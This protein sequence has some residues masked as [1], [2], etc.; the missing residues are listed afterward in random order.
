MTRIYAFCPGAEPIP[1]TW[2]ACLPR[3]RQERLKKISHFEAWQECLSLGLLYAYALEAWGLDRNEPVHILP[4]G[5][6][7]FSARPAV[8]FSLSH[9]GGWVVCA[10]SNQSV[11]VDVQPV[12]GVNLS[13]ARRFHPQERAWLEGQKPEEQE[14]AFFRLWTRKEAWV[15]AQ[16][17]DKMVSLDAWDVMHPQGEWQFWDTFLAPRVPLALCVPQLTGAET[18]CVVERQELLAALL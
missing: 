8:W 15:K 14:Q 17:R 12:R 18:L 6:P 2:T 1:E 13:I 3:W 7:V 11:G 9:G 16:S 4:A 10:L 5:K